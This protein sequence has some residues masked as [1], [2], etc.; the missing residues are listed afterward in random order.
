MLQNISHVVSFTNKMIEKRQLTTVRFVK[1]VQNNLTFDDVKDDE[2]VTRN[3]LK[4]HFNLSDAHATGTKACFS[5]TFES[6]CTCEPCERRRVEW[7]RCTGPR[8]VAQDRRPAASNLSR[9]RVSTAVVQTRRTS[10]SNSE[11]PPSWPSD[12][13]GSGQARP[14]RRGWWTS[15]GGWRRCWRADRQRPDW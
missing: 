2:W 10:A 4:W 6:Y 12:S 7:H 13:S 15:L 8:W 9:R 11:C 3:D 5:R 1:R 14:R